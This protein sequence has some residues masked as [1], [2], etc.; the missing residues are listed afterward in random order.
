VRG[1][2]PCAGLRP[3]RRAFTIAKLLLRPRACAYVD[4]LGRRGAADELGPVRTDGG[5][6][7]TPWTFDYPSAAPVVSGGGCS[8]IGVAH[9][10]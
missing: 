7:F 9:S 8:L 1:P 6:Q 5:Q 10:G 4:T 2:D 3:V